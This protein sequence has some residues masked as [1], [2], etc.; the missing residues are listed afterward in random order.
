M[1]SVKGRNKNRKLTLITLEEDEVLGNQGK[2][3]E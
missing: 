3:S 2:H 1:G